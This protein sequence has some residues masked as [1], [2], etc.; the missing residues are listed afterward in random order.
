MKAGKNLR[1]LLVRDNGEADLLCCRN[2]P[3]LAAGSERNVATG[4]SA[5][6]QF[7]EYRA[8]MAGV[9][10]ITVDRTYRSQTC[11]ECGC[12]G[13]KNRNDLDFECNACGHSMD[14]DHNAARNIATRATGQ[15]KRSNQ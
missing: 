11:S 8:R 15:P 3:W 10:V 12:S 6:F 14:A 1:A 9:P 5:R 4:R 13:R 7:L 2:G